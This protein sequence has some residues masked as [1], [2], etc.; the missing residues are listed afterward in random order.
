MNKKT[1]SMILGVALLGAFFLPF[2]GKGISG[3]DLVSAKGVD[4]KAY[5]LLLLPLSG[6]L[7][8]VGGVNNGNY[9]LSRGLLCLLPLIAIIFILFVAPMIEGAK[10]GDIFKYFGKG[11]GIGMWV[12]VVASLVLAFYSPKD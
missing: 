8:L 1:L 3:L 5:I 11:W 6:L 10:I 12:S 2:Y 4:W 7:L 9:I